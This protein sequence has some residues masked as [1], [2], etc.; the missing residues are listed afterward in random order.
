M[1]YLVMV[2]ISFLVYIKLDLFVKLYVMTP[3][4]ASHASL[5]FFHHLGAAGSMS[6][7]PSR[8]AHEA[9]LVKTRLPENS[10]FVVDN[11][12]SCAYK[13][14]ETGSSAGSIISLIKA[15]RYQDGCLVPRRL[16]REAMSCCDRHCVMGNAKT[17]AQQG[18]D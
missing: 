5:S 18:L 4:T 16:E 11:S 17:A 8:N 12:L 7:M 9:T 3:R 13:P 1:R 10:S 14:E 6:M 15:E 2:K